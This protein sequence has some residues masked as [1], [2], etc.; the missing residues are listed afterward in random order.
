MTLKEAIRA[1]ESILDCKVVEVGD[2]KDRWVFALDWQEGTLSSVVW[3][4][5]KESGEIGYFFPPDEPGVLKSAKK[6]PLKEDT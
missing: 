6:I 2:C 1:A 4:C 5:Y 3:C